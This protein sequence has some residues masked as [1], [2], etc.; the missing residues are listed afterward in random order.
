MTRCRFIGNTNFENSNQIHIRYRKLISFTKTINNFPIKQNT[1]TFRNT[2]FA[3][4]RI[5]KKV[6]ENSK[7]KP[8]NE[9][10]TRPTT[11]LIMQHIV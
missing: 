2:S 4:A 7:N 10:R 1:T 3:Q 8:R 5:P 11:R 9:Y 6:N